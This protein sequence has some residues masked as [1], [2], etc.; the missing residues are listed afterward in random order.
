MQTS[1]GQNF[2]L[3][4][5][6]GNEMI[7]F[8]TNENMRL[9]CES[10]QVSMDGTSDQLYT[11]HVCKDNRFLPVVYCLLPDKTAATYSRMFTILQTAAITAGMT[12]DPDEIMSDFETGLINAVATEFPRARHKG[13]YFHFTQVATYKHKL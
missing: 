11:L 10:D 2:M 12:F 5:E 1:N 3:H 7:I 6:P 8:A 9:L 13:C 4:A